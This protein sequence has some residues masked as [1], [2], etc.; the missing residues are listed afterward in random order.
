MVHNAQRLTSPRPN[1][2]PAILKKGKP[3]NVESIN[4]ILVKAIGQIQEQE[5]SSV[6]EARTK[7]EQAA[8]DK[9]T[10][11]KHGV[12]FRSTDDGGVLAVTKQGDIVSDEPPKKTK[13]KEKTTRRTKKKT[14]QQRAQAVQKIVDS[15]L[16]K[17]VEAEIKPHKSNPRFL[18]MKIGQKGKQKE[19]EFLIHGP[20]ADYMRKGEVRIQSSGMGQSLVRDDDYN[21]FDTFDLRD[22]LEKKFNKDP[23]IFGKL[24]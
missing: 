18:T 7:K 5:L 13:T 9:A 23:S 2:N 21:P 1:E 19:D 10:L 22:K 3:M 4:S 6:V 11:K 16:P 20:E 17:G 24:K 15:M 14:P 8:I 12:K